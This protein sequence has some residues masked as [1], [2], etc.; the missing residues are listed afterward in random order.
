MYP[1]ALS[2]FPAPDKGQLLGSEGSVLSRL[3]TAAI[4]RC[5]GNATLR[6]LL[7]GRGCPAAPFQGDLQK[8]HKLNRALQAGRGSE[9]PD[10]AVGVPVH[11]RKLD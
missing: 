1:K 10:L 9:Q 7:W 3:Y 4:S 8:H 2:K 11:C 5:W 6:C